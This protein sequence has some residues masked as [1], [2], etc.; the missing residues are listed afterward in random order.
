MV[1]AIALRSA[2]GRKLKEKRLRGSKVSA[3]VYLH[4]CALA[5]GHIRETFSS[6]LKGGSFGRD[7]RGV[8]VRLDVFGMWNIHFSVLFLFVSISERVNQFPL[9]PSRRDRVAPIAR[10]SL[11]PFRRHPH[12]VLV[13]WWL[14]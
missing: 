6:A 12:P 11:R 1:R 13:F 2:R 3:K 5:H 9:V 7:F 14:Y 8:C 4:A 10:G